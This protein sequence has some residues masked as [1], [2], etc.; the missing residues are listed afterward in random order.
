MAEMPEPYRREAAGGRQGPGQVRQTSAVGKEQSSS[1]TTGLMEQVV[2]RENLKRALKRVVANKGA[3]GPDGMTVEE[4]TPYLKVHWPRLRDELLGS[5]YVPK[6]VRA[7]DIPKYGGG[8]RRLG[9]PTVLD[10][11][12]QQAV[13]QVLTPV[14]DPAFSESSYGYRP[15]RCAQDA[16]AA[17]RRHVAEGFRWVVDLDVEKFFDR[18]NHD[19]LMARVARKVKDKRLL[20]LIRA[21]LNAGIMV[22]GVVQPRDEG[23][24]Q[25]GPLSPLLSNI[26]LDD[27]DKELERR[28]HRFCRY[29]DDCNVYVQS[30]VAGE[31][32]MG[33]LG[34]FLEKRL[35]LGLNRD[36]S[37]VGRPWD[38]TFL[39]YSM[40]CNKEP[41]LKVAPDTLQR[42]KGDLRQLFRRGRGRALKR[43][44]DEVNQFSRGWVGYFRL[45][46]TK[47]V[48]EGLDEWLRRRCRWLLWRQWKKPRARFK[49]MVSLGLDQKR[50]R[51]STCNGRGPW[52]NSG[53]P[54]MNASVPAGWLAAQ[55]LLSLA[56]E[57]RRLE[58]AT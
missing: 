15:G 24:P 40:T 50:A 41:K 49:R 57:H 2:G 18:V 42:V 36:K 5:R 55:G 14:F 45:A 33:S 51:H 28:D 53:A 56:V 10:R 21:Y 4:L 8:T 46:Q 7:V 3:P 29:A 52:W 26:L 34:R 22:E 54:H 19:V 35:R 6:P 9:V 44:I 32:V 27:L 39:G 1:E 16:V 12:I 11:F 17:G 38:R 20:K 13:L 30:K 47:N 48:F 37:V 25:G 43:V 58:V 31:R 23:T